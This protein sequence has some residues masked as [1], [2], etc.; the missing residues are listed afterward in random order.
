MEP[1]LIWEKNMET[2]E[3]IRKNVKDARRNLS[4]SVV[5]EKSKEICLRIETKDWYQ[6][7]TGVLLVYSAIS[8]E[9]MLDTLIQKSLEKN[10]RLAFPKVRGKEMDFYLVTSFDE[11]EE[12]AFYILE[13]KDSKLLS[14]IIL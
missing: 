9:V 11:L 1:L 14:L 4:K 2:K 12:G 3:S 7:L 13:P 5:E 8:N 6:N 10:Q